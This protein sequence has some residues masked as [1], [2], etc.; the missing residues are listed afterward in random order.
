MKQEIFKFNYESYTTK[1]FKDYTPLEHDSNLDFVERNIGKGKNNQ[2]VL[3]L[4]DYVSSVEQDF[5]YNY[6]N[7]LCRVLKSYVM[8]LV[9]REGDKLS[10]KLFYGFKERN[11]GNSWF[12]NNR[13]VDFLTVNLKTGDVYHGY[14]R[15]YQ[16]K[17]KVL[18]K[19]NKNYFASEPVNGLHCRMRDCIWSYVQNHSELIREAIS[20]FMYEVDGR[21][22]SNELNFDQRLFKFYLDKKGIK[23]PNNFYLY[24]EKMI[25][26]QIKKVL[27]KNSNRLI[28]AFM[29]HNNLNGKKLKTALHLCKELNISL[30]RTAKFLFGD[31][32]I[33]QEENFIINVLNA[34]YTIPERDIPAEFTNVIGKEE[35]RRV[36]N[37]FKQVYF[38][39]ILDSYTFIDHLV[40]YTELKMYGET[41]L[42]W[43]SDE[44]ET[45]FFRNEHLDWTDKLSFY[46]KG[47]YERI[48]PEITYKHLQEPIGDYFPVVLNCSANY[49][50]ESSVQS[51]CVKTYIGKPSNM[52]ISLRKGTYTSEE[53]ATLEYQFY[54]EDDKVKCRRVQSLGK[55][56]GKL[57]DEWIPY[58]LKLDLKM[59]YYVNH[60]DF[61]T[62]KITKTC[63]N[64]TFLESDSY[65]G[66]NGDI[67]WTHKQIEHTG[68]YYQWL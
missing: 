52:I 17:K 65:W 34:E 30:Y 37:L 46:K 19:L 2:T 14:L 49:N 56:N 10:M 5:V 13:N 11:V 27:K 31:D 20:K 51:N 58:L 28:D 32:W 24:A 39:N 33:N 18:K 15:N 47:Y 36:F 7:P 54:K 57:S 55:Y 38:D 53:R 4:N 42:K 35:L 63:K 41:D 26:P 21:K 3:F 64:G 60:E 1:V 59:L 12:K 43:M 67:K 45:Q 22:D 16:N 6:G 62:V 68:A 50:E 66:G 48:Y 61:D 29:I 9:E 23:Y 25:G 40:M 44:A 8:I